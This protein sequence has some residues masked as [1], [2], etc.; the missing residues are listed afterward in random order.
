[1]TERKE[2][3]FSDC[4]TRLDVFCEAGTIT[5][6]PVKRKYDRG[7]DIHFAGTAISNESAIEFIGEMRFVVNWCEEKTK[8]CLG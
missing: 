7:F 4:D 5:A 8:S 1:M 6:I 3:V 2:T